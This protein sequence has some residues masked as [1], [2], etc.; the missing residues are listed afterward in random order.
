MSNFQTRPAHL[1]QLQIGWPLNPTPDQGKLSYPN[2]EQSVRDQIKI[3]LLTQPG[4]MLLHPTFGA[5]LQDML[6]QP[7]TLGTRRRLRD[8]VQKSIARWERRIL[9]DQVDV[10]EVVQK[11][12]AVRIELAYRIRRTGVAHNFHFDLVLGT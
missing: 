4:E 2:L 7:N 3:I 10:W 12:D 1:P 11:P 8:L 6:H 9:L 5:G